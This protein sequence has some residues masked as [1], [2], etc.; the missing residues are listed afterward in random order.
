MAVHKRSYRGYAGEI[1]P[2]WSRF[3]IVMRYAFRNA[4]SSK[5]LTAYFVLCF[6][7]PVACAVAIYLDHNLRFLAMFH[8]T[9]LFTV[10]GD[11]FLLFLGVQGGLAFVLTAL[12]GPGLVSAD[13]ANNALPL[14]FC[15]PFSRLEYLLGKSA[16]LVWLLSL[17]TWIPALVLFVIQASLAAPGWTRSNLW[18]ARSISLGS[19]IEILLFCLLTL[20]LS[21]WIKRKLAAG[22]ALLGVFFAGSA[23]AQAINAVLGTRNGYLIDL[24][25][26]MVTVESHLFGQHPPTGLP[27]EN[28]WLALLAI[29]TF[30]LYLLERKVRAYEVVRG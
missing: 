25:N 24:G 5:L 19:A 1:T 4:F 9:E 3:L 30:C 8:E 15:R 2:L 17:I 11:F 16:V 26:L 20:A 21:A 29:C 14:Y 6:I 22:A 28:A 27:A 7:F 23:F 12:I 10:D 18:M 13:L